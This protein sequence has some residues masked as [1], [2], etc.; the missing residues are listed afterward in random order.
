M[1]IR[2]R[3]VV[4]CAALGAAFVRS[5]TTKAAD[6]SNASLSGRYTFR[7]Y[8]QDFA[9]FRSGLN[10]RIAA[11]GVFVADGKGSITGGS[12]SYNDGGELCTNVVVGGR[13]SILSHGEGRLS[14]TTS[15]QTANCPLTKSFEFN[16]VLGKVYRATGIAYLA[17]MGGRVFTLAS[18][19][20][21]SDVAV[22]GVADRD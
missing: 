11:L 19:R 7:F 4:L 6:F 17:Q 9:N 12:L 2:L 10:N 15:P 1:Q 5:E 22:S 16:V 14:L 20:S 18:G 21:S 3:A 8:G 13:Y